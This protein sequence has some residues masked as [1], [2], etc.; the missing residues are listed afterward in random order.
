MNVSYLA[1]ALIQYIFTFT[2]VNSWVSGLVQE[3][4]QWKLKLITVQS[5]VQI[6]NYS[7]SAFEAVISFSGS[8]TSVIKINT[9]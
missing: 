6:L 7:T 8:D 1:A 2:K 3:S 5:I 9:K 4:L